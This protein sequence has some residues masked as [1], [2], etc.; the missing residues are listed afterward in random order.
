[1]VFSTQPFAVVRGV[2]QG[3]PLSAFLFIMVLEILCTSIRNNKDIHGIVVDNEE[4]K[5]SLFTDDLTCFLKNELYL[6]ILFKTHRRLWKLLG[7]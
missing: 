5:L 1:M 3:D 2:R 4:I 6:T 7:P